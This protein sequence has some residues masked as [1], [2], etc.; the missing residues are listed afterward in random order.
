MVVAVALIAVVLVAAGIGF[1][2]YL[3]SHP[4]DLSALE[5][6]TVAQNGR[7]LTVLLPETEE[8][9]G[10]GL[11]GVSELPRDTALLL[12][13]ADGDTR[14]SM[15]GMRFAL[16]LVWLDAECRVV[17]VAEGAQPGI[18]HRPVYS[19]PVKAA[20]VLEMPAGSAADHDLNQTGTTLNCSDL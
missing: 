4:Q 3:E 16:D 12:R 1:V 20:S 8:Q 14:I 6:R 18:L 5:H 9:K 10:R 15:L 7:E 11:A 13:S 17:H 2:K 19:T